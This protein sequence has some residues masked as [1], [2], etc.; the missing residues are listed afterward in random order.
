MEKNCLKKVM[1]VTILAIASSLPLSA[2]DD[3]QVNVDSMLNSAKSKL[4]SSPNEAFELAQQVVELSVEQGNQLLLAN[5]YKLLG[6]Y[7]S[8]IKN[9]FDLAK[10]NYQKADSIFRHNKGE[11]YAKGIGAI[12]HSYGVIDHRLGNYWEAIQY[13][14]NALRVLDSI[15]DNEIRPKT[16]NNLSNLY[17][18]L[19]DYSRAEKYSREC[20]RVS[21]ENGNKQMISVVSV[22]LADA[23]I[24][25]GKFEEV[26][27]LLL[28]SKEI[29]TE[30]ENL[31]ILELVH[32]NLGSY[33]YL[34]ENNYEKSIGE[35]LQALNYAKAL[36]SDWEVMRITTNVSE[37]Y[38]LDN[39]LGKAMEY[40]EKSLGIAERMGTGDIKQ[41]ALSI[42]AKVYASKGQYS[43]AYEN[44]LK[45]YII[46]DSVFNDS[47]QMHVNY[48]ES[49]Y[50]SEMKEKEII[51]LKN[52]QREHELILKRRKYQLII[53]ITII[54]IVALV[55]AFIIVRNKYRQL[56]DAQKLHIQ[57]QQIKQLEQEKQLVATQAI[58]EGEATERKRLARDLHDGLGG[59][60]SVVKMGLHDVKSGVALDSDD[61]L[62]FNKVLEM[63]D[64]SIR[65]L[66]RVAHNMMPESL[67][68]YGLKASLTDF[69]GNIPN[70]QF[71][72]F[73]NEQRLDSKLEMMI[74]RTAHELVNNALKHA[75][76]QHINIQI[77]QGTDRVS[78]IVQDDGV[79]FD[80]KVKSEG[81]GLDNIRC[82]VQLF[83]GTMDIFSKTGNGTEVNVEFKL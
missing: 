43:S 80:P 29:A 73:G 31:Y 50:H 32:L 18:F 45:S 72:Y 58:L 63:L 4:Y 37:V 12:Y 59:M 17:A 52:T 55:A 33:Y 38:F 53:L 20:L 66:R 75:Q 82:R 14:Y 47:K 62:R 25:Q 41:R 15:N 5:G 36:G 74:Y 28:K 44:L 69:C 24:S 19:K 30:Q 13:Y 21:I 54:L 22:S 35:Y 79:G 42:L 81:T 9:D 61:V 27:S 1:L 76:A 70:V 23:L 10:L 77:V 78:L 56:L 64:S 48:L 60:L 7:Y 65:E 16:L 39:Q 40:A 6:A 2:Q 8:D 3:N 68:R 11:E 26:L 51:I 57:E 83:N 49:R 46:R 71:H 67:M 34:S